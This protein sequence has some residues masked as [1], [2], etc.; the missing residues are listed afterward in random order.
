MDNELDKLICALRFEKL[1]CNFL[2]MPTESH[3]ILFVS[4]LFQFVCFNVLTVSLDSMNYI[5][6]PFFKKE[7]YNQINPNCCD[8][9]QD[10]KM[11]YFLE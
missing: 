3:F 7:T 5:H 1:Q 11:T 8:I 2:H 10:V 6:R 9:G 4:T